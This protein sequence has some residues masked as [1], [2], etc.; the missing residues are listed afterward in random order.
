MT[1]PSRRRF[2]KSA[3]YGAAGAG[4]LGAVAAA[5]ADDGTSYAL[6]GID[7]SH[8]Q[9]SIN[10]I[11]VRSS[12]KRFAFCKATEGTDYTDPTFATNWPAMKA[13]GLLRSAYHMGHPA[14][15]AVAQADFFYDT[16]APS[17]GDLPLVLDLEKTDSMSSTQV[18]SWLVSFVNRLT[19]RMGRAPIIYT[20]FYFWR[21]SAGNG[22]NLGCPLWLAYWG[23]GDP[24][25]FVPAAWST[26]SFWQYTST[27]TCPGISGD[28]DR[29]ACN[30]SKTA[31]NNLRLP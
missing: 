9:G 28:V 15:D 30:L 16:A 2:L 25:S 13:A 5:L 8:W 4:V 23:T 14:V 6:Q 21:D 27:G 7:I 1:R 19:A 17:S 10:W 20:G 24:R 26:F 3:A 12:G 29:D 18:R 11:S 22:S 31:L